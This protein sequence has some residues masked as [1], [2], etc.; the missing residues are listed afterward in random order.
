[1]K[2]IISKATFWFVL[3]GAI[4]VAIHMIGID[5]ISLMIGF[6]PILNALPKEFMYSGPKFLIL[7]SG[8]EFSV[9]WYIGSML[10]MALYGVVIDFI[11]SLAKK[12]KN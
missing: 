11:V 10:T 12:N 5:D 9:Y 6:N 8:R 7:D 3:I 2:K 4:G 1:M